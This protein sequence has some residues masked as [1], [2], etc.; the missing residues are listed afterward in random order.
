VERLHGGGEGAA[1]VAG[2]CGGRGVPISHQSPLLFVHA[3]RGNTARIALRLPLEK[4]F[5]EDQWRELGRAEFRYDVKRYYTLKVEN[6]AARIRA[7]IDGKLVLQAEDGEIVKGKTGLTA[8]IPAR[9]Q[10]FRVSATDEVK[11]QIEARI[12][13]REAELAGL[14]AGNPQPR[15]WKKFATPGYGAGRNVRFGDLDGTGRSTC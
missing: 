5:H 10:D 2:R 15:L 13:R 8:R 7:Y 12:A 14:R 11:K 3:E 6:E 4:A 1:A 9:F